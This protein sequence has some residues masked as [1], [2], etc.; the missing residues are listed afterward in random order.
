LNDNFK[1]Y[2]MP[3]LSSID[4]DIVWLAFAGALLLA[5]VLIGFALGLPA[6]QRERTAQAERDSAREELESLR[7]TSEQAQADVN[8][9]RAASARVS[10]LEDKLVAAGR[11]AANGERVPA[12]E[13]EIAALRDHVV[14]LTA[15]N[16]RL[17]E[18]QRATEEARA[19]TVATLTALRESIEATIAT[20]VDSGLS[21]HQAALVEVTQQ[22][23]HNHARRIDSELQAHQAA[24]DGLVKP[25]TE[26]L[27]KVQQHLTALE[28]ESAKGTASRAPRRARASRRTAVPADGQADEAAVPDSRNGVKEPVSLVAVEPLR[29]VG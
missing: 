29:V 12:L 13:T 28:Q 2:Y 9:A 17:E 19:E 22:T 4:Q 27:D 16:T 25:V 26:S 11:Q 24:I 23:L 1:R 14:A 8:A 10:L 18:A 15:E 20:S 5:G 3:S 7:V 6:R 21:R